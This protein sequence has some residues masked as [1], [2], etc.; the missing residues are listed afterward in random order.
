MPNNFLKWLLIYACWLTLA[1]FYATQQTAQNVFNG[2]QVPWQWLT[3]FKFEFASSI[4]WF[5]LTPLILWLCDQFP[6][7]RRN[8]L[9]RFLLYIVFGIIVVTLKISADALI[10]P[11]IGAA[12]GDKTAYL[13][14]FRAIA[15]YSVHLYFP[16]YIAVVTI[17]H[18]FSYYREI[19]QRELAN[20][21]LQTALVNAQLQT[22]RMQLQP[23]F[24]FNTLQAISTLM[25][26]DVKTADR[27]LTRL[28]DL[29]R[30][31]LEKDGKQEI[32]LREELELLERYL[33]IEQARFQERL[34]IEF[35]IEPATLDILVPNMILQPLVE[36]A[37][38]HGIAPRTN[39]GK[40]EIE[41]TRQNGT[42]YLSIRDDGA[43]ALLKKDGSLPEERVGLTNTRA[44]LAHLYGA[45]HKIGI[46]S[47]SGQGLQIDLEIPCREN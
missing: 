33:E 43:G 12:F 25:Y 36:N 31:T 7:E 21:Q 29:L 10:L 13:D 23:H 3:A 1:A 14:I 15:V 24:L 45:A 38:R 2:V 32:S 26:R 20:L 5:L 39:G 46:K 4:I 11:P 40:I 30:A 37:I 17:A 35:K 19:R 6:I 9:S 28:S 18:A 47:E 44:R 34:T 41:S 8:L 22:L 42:L 27:V 16:T